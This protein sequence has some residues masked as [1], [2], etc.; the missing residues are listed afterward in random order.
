MLE[1]VFSGFPSD[2]SLQVGRVQE[3]CSHSGLET[4]G[5]RPFEVSL[6]GEMLLIPT[7]I[8]CGQKELLDLMDSVGDDRAVVACVGTRH[9][10]GFLRERCLEEVLSS[11]ASYT[12]PYIY[13]LLGEYVVSISA[14]IV[15]HLASG[16][17]EQFRRFA[18]ENP[19]FAERTRQRA[20]SYWQ[21]YYRTDYPDLTAFPS[22][23]A[24]SMIDTLL[25]LESS[26]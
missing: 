17:I 1:A 21:A 3:C 2:Q 10:D 4:R 25:P 8:Y 11:S 18:A 24:L 12:I 15:A 14:K 20:R 13:Q 23:V 7:R 5:I 9:H 6:N 26:A 16:N 22:Y 19:S